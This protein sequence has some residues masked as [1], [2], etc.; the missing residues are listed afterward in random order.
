MR[1]AALLAHCLLQ[2]NTH[3]HPKGQGGGG[4]YKAGEKTTSVLPLFLDIGQ[5]LTPLLPL[6]GYK[7]MIG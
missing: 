4:G 3:S 6:N 7:Y 5:V 2:A 1:V